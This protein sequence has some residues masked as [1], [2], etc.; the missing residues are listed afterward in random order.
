MTLKITLG[1]LSTVGMD[2]TSVVNWF[3]RAVEYVKKDD[4]EQMTLLLHEIWNDGFQKGKK[5]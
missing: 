1:G 3:E 5:G 4:G 2:V